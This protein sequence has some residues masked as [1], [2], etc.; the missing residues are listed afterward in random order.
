MRLP[1]PTAGSNPGTAGHRLKEERRRRGSAPPHAGSLQA[2]EEAEPVGEQGQ[3][4]HPPRPTTVQ[5]LLLSC[6]QSPPAARSRRRPGPAE[7]GDTHGAAAAGW[8]NRTAVPSGGGRWRQLRGRPASPAWAVRAS[9][10][11]ERVEEDRHG[12]PS[13]GSTRRGA[14]GWSPE[15]GCGEQIGARPCRSLQARMAGL[16]PEGLPG[17]R[18]RWGGA[19]F[20]SGDARGRR[21]AGRPPR[22]VATVAV[23]GGD[24]RRLAAALRTTAPCCPGGWGFEHH[25][26]RCGS[27]KVQASTGGRWAR[28]SSGVG[29]GGAARSKSAHVPARLARAWCDVGGR[30]RARIAAGR[31]IASRPGPEAQ[32][33]Q[34]GTLDTARSESRRPVARSM[35]SVT[36]PVWLVACGSRPPHTPGRCR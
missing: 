34:C 10:G 35:V 17:S 29:G 24:D 28:V 20:Q 36:A 23:P 2:P 7:A 18:Q 25:Q 27:R 1:P 32:G 13:R 6:A 4:G 30:Y 33:V 15:L 5:R 9:R 14:W 22:A 8:E 31:V 12:G 11:A 21:S 19:G 3:P 26:S 16:A